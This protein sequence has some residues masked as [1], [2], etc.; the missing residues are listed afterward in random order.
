[1]LS[2]YDSSTSRIHRLHPVTKLTA[3]LLVIAA[4]YLLPGVFTPL[5]LFGLLVLL[6]YAAGVAGPFLWTAVKALLPITFSLFLIQGIL[7][8]P[9]GATPFQLGPLSLTVEGLELA[10][11]TSSR[12]LTLSAAILLLLR[13]TAPGD[14]VQALVERGLPRSIGYI[15]LASLQIAPDMSM[16]ATAILEAQ[17]SRGLETEGTIRRLRS[18]PALVGPLIVGALVDT[19]ERAMALESRAFMAAGPKTTLRDIPDTAAQRVARA[20]LLLTLVALVGW[21]IYRAVTAGS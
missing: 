16:R 15:I 5:A 20:L 8:P 9:P 21:T 18:L 13:T 12:L 7:F 14:L 3:A 19:E 4:A 17:R 1:M 2:I 10:F 6:A 11:V